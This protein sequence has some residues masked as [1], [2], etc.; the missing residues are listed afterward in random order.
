MEK[1]KVL[2]RC[3]TYNHEKYIAQAL[4]GF[5]MQ[6]TNFKFVA[7]VHDDA[8][9][10]RT[11]E[12]VNEYAEKYPDIIKP[13]FETENLYSKHDGSL[14]KVMDD[15]CLQYEP[16]YI[17]VCE[18]DDY[19]TDPY[20]LQKQV[21]FLDT[22]PDFVVCSCVYNLYLQDTNELQICNAYINLPWKYEGEIEYFEY[23]DGAY[24]IGWFT[25]PLTTLYRND[26]YIYDIPADKYT[27]YRDN[28]FYYYIL[29]QGKGALLK[30]VM[31]GYRKHNGGIFTGVSFI[32]NHRIWLTTYIELYNNN[33]G[34]TNLYSAINRMMSRL[35]DSLRTN[36]S[37]TKDVIKMFV[38]YIH[39]APKEAKVQLFRHYSWRLSAK[40]SRIMENLFKR[41]HV[42]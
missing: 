18:G 20:K 5:V 19:W 1:V 14:R 34:D 33:K 4:D 26:S 11:A 31:G 12:I 37:Y 40:T 7:I 6:Q 35:I 15:A 24:N 28:V 42:N 27:Y 9:T 38:Y 29:K 13:I 22:H 10:D 41:S 17:A 2:I 21:D 3:C 25:Q 16:L 36:P 23:M 8:S 30:D 39:K 32:N